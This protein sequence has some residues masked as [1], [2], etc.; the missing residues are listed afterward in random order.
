MKALKNTILKTRPASREEVKTGENVFVIRMASAH[1]IHD[2]S[3]TANRR[4]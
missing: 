3:L 2:Q 1:E 4:S